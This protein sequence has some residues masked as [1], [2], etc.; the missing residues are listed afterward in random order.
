[1]QLAPL[2]VKDRVKS[3]LLNHYYQL[4]DLQGKQI[5]TFHAKDIRL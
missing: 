1:M 4:E 2:F 5:G 3:K